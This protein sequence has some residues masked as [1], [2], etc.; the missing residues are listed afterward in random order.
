MNDDDPTPTSD[1]VIRYLNE[2]FEAL[3]LPY[4]LEHIAVL[5][6]VNPRWMANWDVPQLENVPDRAI[7]EKELI[8][9]RWKFPQV[10]DAL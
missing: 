6:Y 9:A 4:R 3:D 8:E 1:D 5:P 7:I 10:R 2:R